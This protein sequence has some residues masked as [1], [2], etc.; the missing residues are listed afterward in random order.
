MKKVIAIAEFPAPYRV[1][2][3]EKISE[4]YELTVYFNKNN[5]STRDAS[6]PINQMKFRHYFL[7]NQ[8]GKKKFY[9]D[10]LTIKHFE[11]ALVYNFAIKYGVIMFESALRK[12]IPIFINA[13][14][15]FINKNYFKDKVKRHIVR[16]TDLYFSSGKAADNYFLFYGGKQDKVRHHRFT[17]LCQEDILS[18]PVTKAVKEQFKL[19]LGL[20]PKQKYAVAVGQFIERKGFDILLRAWGNLKCKQHLL[21]IGGGDLYEKYNQII[22]ELDLTEYVSVIGFLPKNQLRR[23]LLACDLFILPT[24]EDVWGLVINEAMAVGLPVITTDQ[25]VAGKELIENDVNGYIVPVAST[26]ELSRAID[27]IFASS[28]LA[29]AMAVQNIKKMQGCTMDQI[30][31]R[32][33]EDIDQYLRSRNA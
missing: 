21:L 7:D 29:E 13:D 9:Y 8:T 3:F 30:G 15:G 14:G 18:E 2:V 32:H 17:S 26:E 22:C 33:I 28:Q 27:R 6:Y 16:N 31:V 4:R 12:R 20:I 23:Y 24:R 10:I 25:C 11:F 19:E 1:A 5:D